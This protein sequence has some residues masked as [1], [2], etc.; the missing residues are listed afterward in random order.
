MSKKSFFIIF[1]FIAAAPVFI[2]AQT[3]A[4]L[5]DV[6]ES[7][8]VTCAQAARFTLASAPSGHALTGGA[9]GAFQMARE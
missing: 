3:A 8:A 5:A 4:E 7:H 9:E 2:P 1:C 6:L